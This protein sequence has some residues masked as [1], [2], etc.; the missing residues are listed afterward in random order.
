M[1]LCLRLIASRQFNRLQNRREQNIQRAS[2]VHQQF[3]IS[4]NRISI[5]KL[6]SR[7]FLAKDDVSLREKMYGSLEVNKL[8]QRKLRFDDRIGELGSLANSRGK[9][10]EFRWIDLWFGMP[11]S[12]DDWWTVLLMC[13]SVCWCVG[14]FEHTEIIVFD[15]NS[16]FRQDYF[17]FLGSS[18]VRDL[19]LLF[20]RGN[21]LGS[22][23]VWMCE[24]KCW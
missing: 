14:V 20:N 13:V 17:E 12:C 10:R 24:Y 3:L 23:S 11:S 2:R 9:W 1:Q 4:K 8:R 5:S 19:S 6:S 7:R 22:V 16:L 15:D 18:E 21:N